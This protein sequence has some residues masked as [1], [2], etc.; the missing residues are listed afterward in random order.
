[1]T[2]GDR[3]WWSVTVS[4][5]HPIDYAF[6]LDDDEPLPDPRSRRQPQGPHGASRTFDV[7]A[8]PWTDE[9]W[10]P[11]DLATGVLYEL[12][13]GTF[14]PEGTFD[15]AITRIPHL[16]DLGVT[17]VE[18][19]PV[20]D[21]PGRRGWG[22]DG[23][24]KYAVHE[25]YGGPA[26]FARFVDA[27]HRHGLAVI[28]DVVFN[29]LGPDGNYLGR[30]GPYF[31]PGVRTPWGDAIN[32]DGADSDEVRAFMIGAAV[33]WLRDYHVDGLRLDAIHAIHDNSARPFVAELAASV[34]R[35]ELELGR[36]LVLIAEDDRNDPKVVGDLDRGGW[37]LAAQWADEFHHGLHVALTG[38]R[39]GYYT[40]FN[41]LS[42]L[43]TAIARPFVYDGRYSPSRRKMVGASSR[44]LPPSR[45][46]VCLQ[47][48]DQVGNRARGD[49]ITHLVPPE[50]ARLAAAFVLLSPFIP[51]IFQGEEWAA[52]T[53]FRYFTDHQDPKLG[54][55]VSRGRREEFRAFGWNPAD[56]PDPQDPATFTASKLDWR[57][58]TSEPHASMLSWYRAVLALRRNTP[59]IPGG[60]AT[61]RTDPEAGW[62]LMDRRSLRVAGN[63]SNRPCRV[64]LDRPGRVLLGSPHVT[65]DDATV[66]LPPFSVA[67]LDT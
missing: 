63:F 28:L 45:F 55:I 39:K 35:L 14:T 60:S 33:Q 2:H 51:L 67:I 7:T 49:R 9:A 6:A 53:P 58:L 31:V 5:S 27:A 61:A 20:A 37:G 47:N 8:V 57:E 34:R 64:P 10:D 48:H 65:V 38:E 66:A 3:G 11:P 56:V 24:G 46:V 62:L 29:H 4:G 41:G 1:M 36:R 52:S 59:G 50:K 15:A 25:A 21:F 17:H 18:V 19:M 12:H 43:A 26:G 23:V 42:D 54:R 13:V 16:V 22:Y 40:D 30:F 44:G 32:F